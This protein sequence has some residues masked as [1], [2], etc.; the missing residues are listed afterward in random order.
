MKRTLVA[1][2]VIAVALGACR[3]SSRSSSGTASPG[4]TAAGHGGGGGP[5]AIPGTAAGALAVGDTRL[6]DGSLGDDY[7]I[8][9]TAGQ[10]VT[11]VVRGGPSVTEPGSNLDVYAVLL[12]GTNE[13]AHDDDSAGNLN[14]RIVYT[15]TA[16]GPHTLRVTTYGTGMR[17]GAYTV[18]T[19]T[20][21]NEAAQ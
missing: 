13:V 11:I 16:S 14:A 1:M 20:G 17:Q 3:R 15:P 9:L 10:P 21:A 6:T 8:N 18:Q 4:A 12:N 2:F 7:T 5:I 19:W